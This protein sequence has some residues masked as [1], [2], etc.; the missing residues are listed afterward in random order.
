MTPIPTQ[1]SM[2]NSFM[3]FAFSFEKVLAMKTL[4]KRKKLCRT[5]FSDLRAMTSVEDRAAAGRVDVLDSS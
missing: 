1:N 4:S 5:I 2:G 3:M